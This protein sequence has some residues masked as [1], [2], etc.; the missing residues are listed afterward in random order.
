MEF[1]DSQGYM[2]KPCPGG[3]KK[4]KDYC[5][6]QLIRGRG[7]GRFCFSKLIELCTSIVLTFTPREKLRPNFKAVP[8]VLL[9]PTGSVAL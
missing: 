4:V 3:E 5:M 6:T 7:N 1:Q 2:E 8:K 9:D